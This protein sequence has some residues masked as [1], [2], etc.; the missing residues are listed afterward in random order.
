MKIF[1]M[2][3][4]MEKRQQELEEVQKKELEACMNFIYDYT[5]IHGVRETARRVGVSHGM[6]SHIRNGNTEYYG[7]D[8]I[9]NLAKAIGNLSEE[10]EKK[11][12]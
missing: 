2:F 1:Q 7:F 12:D 8:S 5:E 4:K 9:A 6:I 11:S 10:T 3:K